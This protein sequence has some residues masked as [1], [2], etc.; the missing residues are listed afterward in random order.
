MAALLAVLLLSTLPSHGLVSRIGHMTI[1]SSRIQPSCTLHDSFMTEFAIQPDGQPLPSASQ[2]RAS[3]PEHID[4]YKVRGAPCW[5]AVAWARLPD[6]PS[7]HSCGRAWSRKWAKPFRF[8]PRD[9]KH[10]G[11]ISTPQIVVAPTSSTLSRTQARLD[12]EPMSTSKQSTFFSSFFFSFVVAQL[13]WPWFGRLERCGLTVS[14]SHPPPPSPPHSHAQCAGHGADDGPR[15][16]AHA[17]RAST[18]ELASRT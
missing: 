10:S 2:P 7:M 14:A 15:H 1:D 11:P 12:S 18:F 8:W 3:L 17:A 5:L 9:L 13:P 6:I 16:R 4:R